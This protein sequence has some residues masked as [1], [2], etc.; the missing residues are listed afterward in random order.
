MANAIVD[1][2]SQGMDKQISSLKG[3]LAKLR[4]GRASAALLE[5]VHVDYYGSS[6]PVNQVANVT[7]PDARTI[8]VTPWEQGTIGA[9][10]KAILAANIGLTPQNDGKVIRI[11]L[12]PMTEERRKEMVKVVKKMGEEAKVAIRNQRRDA[13]DLVKKDKSIPEDE[14]KKQMDVIQKKT[15]EKTAEVDKV[16][17]TKEKEIMTI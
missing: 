14:S 5:P 8:Q 11:S 4:T 16:V 10:E 1:Q 15:D 7:T 2:M 13:N 9:I 6:V 12:P 17:A 3:E